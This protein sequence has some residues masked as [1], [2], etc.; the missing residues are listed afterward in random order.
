VERFLL[1]SAAD[2]MTADEAALAAEAIEASPSPAP[3]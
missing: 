2:A 1:A 3:G